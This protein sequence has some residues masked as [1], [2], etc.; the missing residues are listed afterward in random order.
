MANDSI[1]I[2]NE[3]IVMCNINVYN[4]INNNIINNINNVSNEILWIL[5][6]N[7]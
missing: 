3:I 4:N 5:M 6:T 1:N 7:D 2:N